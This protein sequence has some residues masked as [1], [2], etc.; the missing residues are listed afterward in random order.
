MEML[1]NRLAGTAHPKIVFALR[2]EE[3]EMEDL[4]GDMG[5]GEGG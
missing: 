3:T 2:A 4:I 5:D 1:P